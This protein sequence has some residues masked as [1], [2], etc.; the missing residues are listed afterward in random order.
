M[1]CPHSYVETI[2]GIG[3]ETLKGNMINVR[4]QQLKFENVYLEN[5]G[6]EIDASREIG[7]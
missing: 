1:K 2:R 3:E 5:V 6:S 4:Y 7:Y